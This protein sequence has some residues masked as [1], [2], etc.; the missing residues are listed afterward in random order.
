MTNKPTEDLQ[1]KKDLYVMCV[2]FLQAV[3]AR[4]CAPCKKRTD[5]NIT[6]SSSFCSTN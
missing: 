2:V 5:R 6:K 3:S 1:K 4:H